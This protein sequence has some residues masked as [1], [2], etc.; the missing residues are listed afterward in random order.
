MRKKFIVL[1]ESPAPEPGIGNAGRAELLTDRTGIN[2][3]KT[4]KDGNIMAQNQSLA[5]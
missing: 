2:K 5:V 4:K 1:M 3:L